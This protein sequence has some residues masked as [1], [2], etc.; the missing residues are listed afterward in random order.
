MRLIFRIL[1]FAAAVVVPT[2]FAL[3]FSASNSDDAFSLSAYQ[4]QRALETSQSLD[5]SRFHFQ[6]L[7]VDNNNFYGRIAEGILGRIAE[8]NDALFTLFPASA[9]VASSSQAPLD[10]A[11]P[12]VALTICESLSLCPTK[13]ADMGTNFDLTLLESCDLVIVMDDEI[14]SLILRS[15]KTVSDQDYYAPKCRLLSEFL[16]PQFCSISCSDQQMETRDK[17][18]LLQLLNNMLDSELFERV[19]PFSQLV[20]VCSSSVFSTQS[21]T[22]KDLYEPRMVLTDNGAAIAN[23]KGWLLVEAAMIVASAG[24][25]RFCLDTMDA[26]FELAFKSL[27]EQHF[28]RSEHLGINWEQADDQLR[29]GSFSVTGYFS[30]EQRKTRFERHLEDLRKQLEGEGRRG[31][32]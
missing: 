9:T 22:W 14:R 12:E 17:D 13:S 1:C 6:I 29:R 2:C 8:F 3:A 32:S 20:Q 28:R 24:I 25:V 7:F 10:A 27:L 16:S 26:Q 4:K 23:T 31:P 19:R 21:T 15:L 5:A 30:P 11:A 18:G